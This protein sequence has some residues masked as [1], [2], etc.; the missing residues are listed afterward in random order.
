[1]ETMSNENK[2]TS[3]PITTF[4]NEVGYNEEEVKTWELVD[5]KTVLKMTNLRE[6][7]KMILF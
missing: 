4:L 7:E 1:M 2:K 5:L 3:D 6:T